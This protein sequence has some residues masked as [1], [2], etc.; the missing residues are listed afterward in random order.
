M[1]RKWRY[2]KAGL[3]RRL[4]QECLVEPFVRG[5]TQC[6]ISELVHTLQSQQVTINTLK[7]QRI[8]LANTS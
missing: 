5:Y 7:N 2:D 3:I 6:I 1:S 8:Q 4:S